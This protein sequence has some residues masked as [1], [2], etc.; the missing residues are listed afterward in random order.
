M[1]AV[2]QDLFIRSNKIKNEGGQTYE[3][4]ITPDITG[5]VNYFSAPNIR[6]KIRHPLFLALKF[7]ECVKLFYNT[8]KVIGLS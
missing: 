5:L 6:N 8:K 4:K 3:E 7:S 1:Q 2:E